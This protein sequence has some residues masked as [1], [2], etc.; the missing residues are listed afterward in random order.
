M[1]QL[2]GP[3]GAFTAQVPSVLPAPIVHVP[4]QQSPPVAH[5]SPACPQKDAAWQVPPLQREEQ[6]CMPEVQPLPS[7]LQVVLREAHL[8]AVH[9]WL[10]QSPFDV[11]AWPSDV[12]AGYAQ[13]EP[14]QSPLQQSP[15][16]VHADPNF[17]QLPRG[18]PPLLEAPPVPP[19][20]APPLAAPLLPPPAPLPPLPLKMPGVREP[21][22]MRP[23][24]LLAP[25]PL[26]PLLLAPVVPSPLPP[27][28]LAPLELL[29]PHP[30]ASEP[31]ATMDSATSATDRPPRSRF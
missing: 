30:V 16:E 4:V 26:V 29:P 12:H 17:R 11:Q 19:L 5:A 31:A 21:S 27:S 7:V 15:F 25:A 9:V 13:S 18:A 6:H 22:P 2:A 10:Q 1:P 8:P 20:L 14:V 24:P 3:L 28:A 23:A